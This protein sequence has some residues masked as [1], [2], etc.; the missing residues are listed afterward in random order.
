VHLDIVFD[1]HRFN[2]SE[3]QPHFINPCCFGEDF[4]AWL[5]ARL[6]ERGIPTIAPG[7]EDWGW[8]I[9]ATLGDNAYFIGV[10]G[11]ADETARDPNQGQWRIMIEKH[12]SLWEKVTGKNHTSPHEPIFGVIEDVLAR[13]PD[14]KNVRRE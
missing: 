1:T 12:R 14:F 9:V 2:L 6:I 10:G 7:Q 3:V 13:E 11:N 4:A 8:Y 5:R